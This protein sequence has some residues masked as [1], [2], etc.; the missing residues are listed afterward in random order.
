MWQR[1]KAEGA[2]PLATG[3]YRLGEWESGEAISNFKF[4]ISDFE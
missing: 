1:E 3:E 2:G 4:E